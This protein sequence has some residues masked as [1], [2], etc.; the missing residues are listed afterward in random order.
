MLEAF[1]QARDSRFGFAR[2]RFVRSSQTTAR[3]PVTIVMSV[4]S[5]R[6]SELDGHARKALCARSRYRSL[7]LQIA[8]SH[9][10]D[11][12]V[13]IKRHMGVSMATSVQLCALVA[14]YRFLHEP[15]G[16]PHYSVQETGGERVPNARR[17]SFEGMEQ[18][19]WVKL[20]LRD[21]RASK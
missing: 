13:S 12:I 4:S 1:R 16:K 15:T 9:W 2:H 18:T 21:V 20:R 6:P 11:R 7:C 17:R 19:K 8:F 3:W 10:H 14:R 5:Q